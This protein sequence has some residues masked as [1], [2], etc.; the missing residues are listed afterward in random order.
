MEF[1]IWSDG[2]GH[3]IAT[4]RTADFVS[5]LDAPYG[6]LRH[7][8]RVAASNRRQALAMYRAAR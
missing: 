2:N 1:D 5:D 4:A 7:E 3:V 8:L 6:F